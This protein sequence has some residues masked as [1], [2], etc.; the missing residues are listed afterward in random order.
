MAVV[1]KL[2][3]RGAAG[4]RP[5]GGYHGKLQPN[6]VNACRVAVGAFSLAEMANCTHQIALVIGFS[7]SSTCH[8]QQV[9]SYPIRTAP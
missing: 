2:D 8:T 1:E 5:G 6:E 9:V 4:G 3:M 7:G